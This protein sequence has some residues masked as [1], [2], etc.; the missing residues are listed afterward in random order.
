MC[1]RACLL[2][3][4]IGGSV[5]LFS[6]AQ[7]GRGGVAVSVLVDFSRSFAPLDAADRRALLSVAET[8]AELS[9]SAW[10]PPVV[11]SWQRIVGESLGT[12]PECGPFEYEPRLTGRKEGSDPKNLRARLRGCVEQIV[13]K[14]RRWT[15][16][17]GWTD[18]RGALR[19]A[20]ETAGRRYARRVIVVYSDF[21]EDL[22]PGA[23]PAR[24]HF[25]GHEVVL[26]HRPPRPGT[27]RPLNVHMASIQQWRREIISAGARAA[28][29][30]PVP[31][32]TS[33]RLKRL[34]EGAKAGTLA[35]FAVLTDRDL[36]ARHRELQVLAK[37][38]GEQVI[39]AEANVSVNWAVVGSTYQ[40]VDWLPPIEYSATLTR[41]EAT[42][43]PEI[44][45]GLLAGAAAGL[46]QL[47]APTKSPFLSDAIRWAL[48]GL[49]GDS[50][51][52]FI[53]VSRFQGAPALGSEAAAWTNTD[54]VLI[55]EPE[56]S[57]LW[58]PDGF[59]RRLSDWRAAFEGAG[60]A[61]RCQLRMGYF[62]EGQL[63][64]CLAR[65]EMGK[66]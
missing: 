25:D 1:L 14:S 27:A 40:S 45:R 62:T 44:F 43:D 29:S 48:E 7:Q 61:V 47:A 2:I 6:C 13:E 38:L 56:T 16:T 58:E 26:I 32:L 20:S 59:Y 30:C 57:D 60:A 33:R 41:R 66:P 31:F 24:L 37:V 39:G 65:P 5:V 63:R 50:S 42:S 55:G 22:S 4:G 52:T 36:A 19:L 10:E 3:I 9:T 53:I 11:C 21:E 64:A 12:Q 8:I 17:A 49:A 35:G 54:I 23:K 15:E 18:I 34:L 51:R 28:A 46:K